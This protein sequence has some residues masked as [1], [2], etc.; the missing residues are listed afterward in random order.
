MANVANKNGNFRTRFITEKLSK[1]VRR[2]K[3]NGIKASRRNIAETRFGPCCDSARGAR[4]NHNE[5]PRTAPPLNLRK[6]L[7][8]EADDSRSLWLLDNAAR[9]PP[10]AAPRERVCCGVFF[11]FS[12]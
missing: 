1:I 9:Q 5:V 7:V 10:P 11:R 4:D 3:S 2:P 12:K 8:R 6:P